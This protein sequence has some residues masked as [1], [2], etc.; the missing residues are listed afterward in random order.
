MHFVLF[1]EL[2]TPQK[3]KTS[4]WISC[5]I[6]RN[7]YALNRTDVH[8]FFCFVLFFKV[9]LD[10]RPPAGTSSWI[11]A[12]L[13]INTRGSIKIQKN[14]LNA[15]SGKP[16]VTRARCALHMPLSFSVSNM[17]WGRFPEKSLTVKKRKI[18]KKKSGV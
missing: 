1:Q 6:K 13:K 4:S 11:T 16:Q 2:K 14:N 8:I 18:K 9:T 3:I 10:Y 5:K 15:N 12:Q 17:G 7:T